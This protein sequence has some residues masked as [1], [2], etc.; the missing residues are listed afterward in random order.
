MSQSKEPQAW[1]EAWLTAQR[2]AWQRFL[3]SPTEAKAPPGPQQWLEA[4]GGRLPESPADVTQKLL[5]FGEGYLGIARQFWQAIEV[6]NA[7]SP[8]DARALE[9]ALE[10]V[11]ASFIEGFARLYGGA[12]AGGDLLGAWQKL[13]GA[14]LGAGG[15]AATGPPGVWPAFGAT[16]EKQETLERLGRAWLRY[17][18]ALQRFSELLGRVAGDAVDRLAKA[19]AARAERQEPP[20]SLRAVY[21]LW[22]ES[23]EQAYAAAAHAAEFAAV[24]AE[25]AAALVDVRAEQQKIAE[26]WARSLDLPTRSEVNTLLKR[27]NTLRRR[28]RELEEEIEELRRR[29]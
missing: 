10:P 16:R 20:A 24:Q 6:A 28:V 1:M 2:D 5:E 18:K 26:D 3:A 17:Q 11:R 8:G 14:A 21:D 12:P 4:F 19:V 7:A 27:V 15:E 13:A 25:L 22:I 9:R 29:R 23:G